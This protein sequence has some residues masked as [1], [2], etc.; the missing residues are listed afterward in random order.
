MV[1]VPLYYAPELRMALA[2]GRP[3][4]PDLRCDLFSLSVLLHE[5]LLSS[6]PATGYDDTPEKVDAA[7]LKGWLHDPQRPGRKIGVGGLP[8][9][10]LSSDI[11]RMFRRAFSCEPR[12][13]PSAAEW[14]SALLNVQG[15]LRYCPDQTCSMPFLVDAAKSSC[16]GCHRPFPAFILRTESGLSIRVDSASVSV[17]RNELGGSPHVSLQHAML[18]KTGPD[19]WIESLGRNGTKRWDG[20]AWTRLPDR[21]RVLLQEGDWLRL[22]DVAARVML[23]A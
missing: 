4:V 13:R 15:A 10:I 3:A 5:I 1:G 16:P 11:H 9:E 8:P 21:T 18:R 12:V 23:A 7:M 6:H 14:E 22:G 20:S 2:A 17:G 19:L